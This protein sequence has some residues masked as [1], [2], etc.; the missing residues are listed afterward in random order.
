MW[1]PIS[2]EKKDYFLKEKNAS[3][4]VHIQNVKVTDWL[5]YQRTAQTTR[6]IVL[7]FGK[8]IAIDIEKN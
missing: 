2:K 1:L 7:K 6:S 8:Q 3:L 4:Y 5:I